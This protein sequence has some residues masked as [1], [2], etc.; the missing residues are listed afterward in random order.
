MIELSPARRR[1]LKA[2]AHH[3][4]PVAS[5]A[6]KGL[7]PSVLAEIDRCLA[8]H[9]LIKVKL[10]G[11]ERDARALIMDE[12]CGALG[13]TAIQHIGNILVLWREKP[14]AEKSDK[15]LPA[16]AVKAPRRGA[17][18]ARRFESNARSVLNAATRGRPAG[19]SRPGTPPRRGSTR[20]R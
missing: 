2:A 10:Y 9:E 4:Q 19:G 18:P 3:L 17:D 13:A 1:E 11:H 7:S 5:V 15:P 8:A 16:K 20:T 12:V 14:A 6:A